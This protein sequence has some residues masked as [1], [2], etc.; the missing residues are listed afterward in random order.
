VPAWLEC[1]EENEIWEVVE[2]KCCA[3]LLDQAVLLGIPMAVVGEES[4]YPLGEGL[5]VGVVAP[6]PAGQRGH[7]IGMSPNDTPIETAVLDL[8][9]LWAGPYCGALLAEA[10]LKVTK[11]ESPNRPDPT[12]SDPR[13]NGRKQRLT[14][15]LTSPALTQM[16]AKTNILITSA[17]PHALARLGLTEERLFAL[18][19]NLIWVAITAYGW[20]GDAAMC[21]GFG[22]DCAAAGGLL[23]WADGEPSFIGDA[24]A[25][26]LTGMMA[27][28]QAMEALAAGKPGLI[29][30]ALAQTAAY[31]ARKAGIA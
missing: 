18:N 17:R 9:A 26:P 2:L 23:D 29:D 7:P 13:L 11:V 10:G 24:L 14:L 25:D 31:F 1:G 28:I 3:E 16:V 27:A 4:P 30:V 21:V 15:D 22:D 12:A 5:G 6:R 19:P 20:T 8:S